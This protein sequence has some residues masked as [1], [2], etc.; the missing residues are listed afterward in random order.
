MKAPLKDESV[1]GNRKHF[2]FANVQIGCGAQIE[3][4]NI[5]ARCPGSTKDEFILMSMIGN[6]LQAGMVCL[7][8][9]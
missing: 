3:L 2:N 9:K 1:Y 6:R 7:F 4:T 8:D 5:I